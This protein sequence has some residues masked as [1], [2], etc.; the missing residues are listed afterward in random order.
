LVGARDVS[1][2]IA[3]STKR[4]DDL[5]RSIQL[6]LAIGAAPEALALYEQHAAALAQPSPWHIALARAILQSHP[7]AAMGIIRHISADAPMNM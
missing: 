4:P 5:W 2:L 6:Q 7:D 3:Q 1:L